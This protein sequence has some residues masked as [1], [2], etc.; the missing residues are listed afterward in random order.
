MISQLGKQ[1]MQYTYCLISQEVKTMKLGQL[2]EYNRGN[3]FLAKSYTKCGKET[4][5]KYL[6]KNQ[7]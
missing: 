4:I 2:I 5:P 7:N 3:I 6:C 1:T